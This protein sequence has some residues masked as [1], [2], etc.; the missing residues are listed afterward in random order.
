MQS[1]EPRREQR[2]E[3]GKSNEKCSPLEPPVGACPNPHLG[4]SLVKPTADFLSLG[5]FLLL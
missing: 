5:L 3:A 4:C 2:P 1:H